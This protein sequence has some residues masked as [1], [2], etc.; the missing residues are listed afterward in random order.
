MKKGMVLLVVAFVLVVSG[1]FIIAEGSAIDAPLKAKPQAVQAGAGN[2]AA[3]RA[4][5]A[6]GV[7]S[8]ASRIHLDLRALTVNQKVP[9][10]DAVAQ[11]KNLLTAHPDVKEVTE[12]PG[13]NLFVRFKDN[14]ELLM[15]LGEDRRGSA[16]DDGQVHMAQ[17]STP[18]QMKPAQSGQTQGATQ[19]TVVPHV[20][21]TAKPTLDFVMPT[22]SPILN[23]ALVFDTLDDDYS[24]ISPRV[25][26][27]VVNKLMAMGFAVTWITNNNASLFNAALIDDGQYDII[28]I[29]SHGASLGNDYMFL[30]RPWYP[31]Y[32][33]ASSYTGTLRVSAYSYAHKTTMFAYA[34]NGSFSAKYWTNKPFP[35][36][37]FLMDACHGTDTGSLPGMPTWVMNHGASAW[38]GWNGSVSFYCGDYGSVL[39][40]DKL[41]T[42][43]S[44]GEAVSAVYATKCRPPDLSL[45][46][47]VKNESQCKLGLSYTD[48]NE[49]AIPDNQDFKF[50]RLLSESGTIY[51]T[52]GFYAFPSF[53]EFTIKIDATGDG[54]TDFIVKC[55]PNTYEVY[56]VTQSGT[57]DNWIQMNAPLKTGNAYMIALPWDLFGAAAT[58]KVTFAGPGYKDML[59]DSGWITVHK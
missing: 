22:C 32:P 27:Q 21:P 37:I 45:F 7:T 5:D 28:F 16:F 57:N 56:K 58:V 24:G 33:P 50:V 53:D 55:H 17:A 11:Q 23:R 9:L 18:A 30:V 49:P 34:F 26:I 1:S 8:L 40:L 14:N 51:A 15:L 35:G 6:K 43:S 20:P 42:G 10:K 47:T 38:L 41:R 13:Y 36:T 39:F 25:G 31:A 59:P 48:A 29:S 2:L 54:K 4:I 44:I 3:I 52:I 46:S 12:T 19:Q